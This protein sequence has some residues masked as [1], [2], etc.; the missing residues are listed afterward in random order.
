MVNKFR[1]LVF[2][3]RKWNVQR[4]LTSVCGL[5]GSFLIPLS[6]LGTLDSPLKQ[7]NLA[8]PEGSAWVAL[9][10]WLHMQLFMDF[11]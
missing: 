9:K 8:L 7:D 5:A 3:N 10:P 4:A 6:S 1:A 2:G 11:L